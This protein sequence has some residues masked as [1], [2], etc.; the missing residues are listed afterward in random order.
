MDATTTSIQ[1]SPTDSSAGIDGVLVITATDPHA[2][3]TTITNITI[4]NG[5]R[6]GSDVHGGGI[7]TGIFTTVT[8]NNSVISGNTVYGI[9]ADSPASGGGIEDAGTLTLNNT[10]VSGNGAGGWNG[11]GGGI[12]QTF[13]G[14][15]RLTLNNT[16]V[17]GNTAA[18][19]GGGVDSES[20]GMLALNNSIISGN[21]ADAGGGIFIGPGISNAIITNSTISENTATVEGGGIDNGGL[22]LTVANSTVSRNRVTS[23]NGSGGGINNVMYKLII[24]TSTVS[25]NTA[26]IGGAIANHTGGATVNAS[27]IADNDSGTYASTEYGGYLYL[28]N[29]LLANTPANCTFG[30]FSTALS[31]TSAD[32]NLSSDASCTGFT[33]PHDLNNVN[34]LVGPLANNGGPTQTHALLSGSPAIDRIPMTGTYCPATDQRGIARPQGLACDIGAFES[35]LNPAPVARPS[36]P[37][38]PTGPPPPAP[39]PRAG[40]PP[41]GAGVNPPAPLPPHR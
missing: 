18:I 6:V 2:A 27:T 17:S 20:S 30:P 5:R 29:S 3:A 35:A 36:D 33:G 26:R 15:T 16:T 13:M 39:S 25:G 7:K 12:R 21:R 38:N 24:T 40:M 34:P 9:D 11:S 8:L 32:Y 1:A 41:S 31:P 4:R 19:F 23:P 28:R 14:F 10:R 37:L 22:S